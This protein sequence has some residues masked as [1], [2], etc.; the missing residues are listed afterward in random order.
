MTYDLTV[1]GGGSGGVC[2]VLLMELVKV[3]TVLGETK[4]RA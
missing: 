2:A 3:F 4:R 1:I